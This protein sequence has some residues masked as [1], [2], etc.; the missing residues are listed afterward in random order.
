MSMFHYWI[1][2]FDSF[3]TLKKDRKKEIVSY[4]NCLQ[5]TSIVYNKQEIK[6]RDEILIFQYHFDYA[7]SV[8]E[9]L[10]DKIQ[11]FR[12]EFRHK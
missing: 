10:T 8:L 6:A 12:K 9:P 2:V 1:E 7:K 4:D 5:H 3:L 11:L